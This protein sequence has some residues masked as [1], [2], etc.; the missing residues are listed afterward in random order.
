MKLSRRISASPLLSHLVGLLTAL[1]LV[2]PAGGVVSGGKAPSYQATFSYDSS[3][4]ATAASA[5]LHT[6]RP[7]SL[8]RLPGHGALPPNW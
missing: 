6:V 3:F 5:S 2:V 4:A 7:R 8:T 1:L